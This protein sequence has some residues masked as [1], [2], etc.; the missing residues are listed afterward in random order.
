MIGKFISTVIL[1]LAFSLSS[2]AE[3][4]KL[5]ST[6]AFA[7]GPESL[8]NALE[9]KG[10]RVVLEDGSVACELWLRKSLST[11]PRKDAGGAFYTEIADSTLVGVISYPRGGTDFRGQALKPGAYTLRYALHPTDGN[12]LGI[13][14]VRD[15][16]VMTPVADDTNIDA[17]P[18]FEELMQMSTKASL[19]TH[20]APLSLLPPEAN[21]NAATLT[22]NEEGFVIFSTRMKT[23]SGAEIPISFIVKGV[24][25]Q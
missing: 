17:Q 1:S 19:T 12:H 7:D 15:F 20:P 11:Q 24:V 22:Q 9:D 16:L 18:K 6:G 13:S 14:P 2:L 8:R 25:R 21:G 5:E 4:A 10:Y 23:A 3:G